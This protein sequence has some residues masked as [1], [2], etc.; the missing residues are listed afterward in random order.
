MSI[1]VLGFYVVF[2][3]FFFL[4]SFEGI[5]WLVIHRGGVV[6]MVWGEGGGWEQRKICLVF[7]SFL[8][9]FGNVW[10][11]EHL[12]I[13]SILTNSQKIIFFFWDS[14]IS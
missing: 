11:P 14:H 4:V 9:M 12:D 6:G 2:F 5:F 10:G 3:L 1:L 7:S 13:P 8:G